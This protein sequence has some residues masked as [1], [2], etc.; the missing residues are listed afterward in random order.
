[1]LFDSLSHSFGNVGQLE[2]ITSKLGPDATVLLRCD[3]IVA[4][5]RWSCR[6]RCRVTEGMWWNELD[7]KKSGIIGWN[8]MNNLKS[9]LEEHQDVFGLSRWDEIRTMLALAWMTEN[10]PWTNSPFWFVWNHGV[11]VEPCHETSQYFLGNEARKIHTR[12]QHRLWWFLLSTTQKIVSQKR[13][14]VDLFCWRCSFQPGLLHGTTN[15]PQD[16][17]RRTWS[18]WCSTARPNVR[19][20]WSRSRSKAAEPRRTVDPVRF[21]RSVVYIWMVRTCSDILKP[22]LIWFILFPDCT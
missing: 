4:P 18:V 5:L 20:P 22:R 16:P 14:A 1:M 19:N 12:G 3:H 6:P 21:G 17:T 13:F 8:S 15:D 11:S 2:E 9:R 10:L 7:W